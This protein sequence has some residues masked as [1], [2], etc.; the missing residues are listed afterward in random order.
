MDY[1]DIYDCFQRTFWKENLDWPNGL[2]PHA[3]KKNY[4]FRE[5]ASSST[6]AFLTEQEAIDFCTVWNE[7]NAAGRYSLKAEF[8]LRID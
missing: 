2:E 3:G 8:E 5:T 4:R 6:Q 1:I 7:N